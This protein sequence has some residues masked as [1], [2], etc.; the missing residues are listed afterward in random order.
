MPLDLLRAHL[1]TYMPKYARFYTELPTRRP[2]TQPPAGSGR[3]EASLG[4]YLGHGHSGV[5]FS[6]KNVNVLEVASGT[7]VPPLVV[8]IA[9]LNRVTS[10]MREAWF[11]DEMECLQGASIARCYG[12]FEMEL[13]DNSA[14]TTLQR[15]ASKYP[16]SDFRDMNP[17]LQRDTI[18]GPLH[19]LLDER[20]RQRDV[21]A[22]LILE[23]L[24]LPLPL[25]Q[26]VLQETR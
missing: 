18:L 26:P 21:L 14:K 5:V 13:R 11:Y 12:Y 16:S 15:L 6:L 1:I 9:R 24:G 4:D 3:L 25:G 23:R 20:S 8:K 7:V 19:P 22:I 10:L 17:V 2:S